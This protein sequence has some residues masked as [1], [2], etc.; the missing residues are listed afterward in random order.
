MSK[1]FN[2]ESQLMRFS[3]SNLVFLFEQRVHYTH[4]NAP[5]GMKRG[6]IS[7]N[8]HYYLINPDNWHNIFN[9]DFNLCCV[10]PYQCQMSK[11]T[12]ILNSPKKMSFKWQAG[13]SF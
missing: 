13:L 2:F 6:G 9:S 7:F 5:V 12:T 1:S 3:G 8:C 10:L 11:K 4:L